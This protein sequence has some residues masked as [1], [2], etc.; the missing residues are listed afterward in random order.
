MIFYLDYFPP[1]IQ[2]GKVL[3]EL[4]PAAK[5]ASQLRKEIKNTGDKFRI[6][7]RVVNT[8][9]EK[10]FSLYKVECLEKA[11]KDHNLQTSI[12][13]FYNRSKSN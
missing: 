8:G 10:C 12:L 4:M 9:K 11:A 3:M 5:C 2:S 7:V 13:D 6:F 1:Q